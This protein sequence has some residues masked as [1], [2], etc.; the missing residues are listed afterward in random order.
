VP[1]LESPVAAVK[2]GAE[3]FTNSTQA[4]IAFKKSLTSGMY[5]YIILVNNCIQP[6][7]VD[8]EGP[9]AKFSESLRLLRADSE[10]AL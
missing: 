8:G 6:K 5:N 10:A 7:G 2:G 9:V 4:P 3:L 1:I